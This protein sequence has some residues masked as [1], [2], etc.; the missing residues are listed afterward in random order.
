[1]SFGGTAP[2]LSS[3]QLV[4]HAAS[5]PSY[6]LG[7]ASRC[8]RG[9]GKHW[10]AHMVHGHKKRYI[11]CVWHVPTPPTTTTTTTTLPA[12]GVSVTL[13]R[14]EPGPDGWMPDPSPL[15]TGV[16]FT[17]LASVVSTGNADSQ[18]QGTVTFSS[19]GAALS[20]CSNESLFYEI[21]GVIVYQGGRATCGLQF[22][23]PGTYVLGAT[24]S[25]SGF[26]SAATTITV[27]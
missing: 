17:L 15:L 10:R 1:M 23:E 25:S 14:V 20:F 12:A 6:P 21:P 18:P 22:N 7:D 26:A 19:D 4:P 3:Y 8:R 9:Y 13:S 5:H 16:P 11:E 2:A 24:Y 27:A